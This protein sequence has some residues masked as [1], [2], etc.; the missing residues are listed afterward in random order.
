MTGSQ[1]VVVAEGLTKRF[2]AFTAVDRLDLSIAKGEVVVADESSRRTQL[3]REGDRDRLARS[4][5][6]RRHFDALSQPQ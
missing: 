2:G 1:P 6:R 4:I 3:T 5:E